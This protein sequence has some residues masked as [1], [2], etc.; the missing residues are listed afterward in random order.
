M[1]REHGQ[2]EGQGKA[3]RLTRGQMAMALRIGSDAAVDR[4]GPAPQDP[5]G[6]H[7]PPP[8]GVGRAGAGITVAMLVAGTL[9]IQTVTGIPAVR[10]NSGDG[11]PSAGAGRGSIPRAGGGTGAIQDN[12]SRQEQQKMFG[13]LTGVAAATAVGVSTTIAGAQATAVQ[14]RVEDGGNGHWYRLFPVSECWEDAQQRALTMGGHL[15]TFDALGEQTFVAQ[16][17]QPTA[18]SW[19]GGRRLPDADLHSGW[20]WVDGAPWIESSIVWSK[21]NPGCCLPNEYYLSFANQ[22]N[23]GVGDAPVC[24]DSIDGS[25]IEW[26]ADCNNDGIVDYGQ[27]LQGQ[28]SDLNTDGVPDV[29]QQAACVAADLFRDFNV[30]G[31]DLGILL[32]QWGPINPLTVADINADGAVN[33][34]DLGLL[35][36]AWGPCN[37]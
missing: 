10:T 28:L 26:S 22:L 15:A 24:W 30:N 18:W 19:I 9:A 36:A 3:A 8:A 32:S 33:G 17:M 37:D 13:K 31:A 4:D 14:W 25:I 23:P 27:I 7:E 34:A 1:K 20:L 6:A 11:P 2:E 16:S 21:G 12:E 29:C 5:D 35:L